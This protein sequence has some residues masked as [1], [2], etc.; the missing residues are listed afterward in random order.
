MSTL[1]VNAIQDT[2][3]GNESTAAEINTGRLKAWGS[4]KGSG[5]VS[6]HASYNFSSIT[7]IST[8]RYRLNFSTNMSD[9]NYSITANTMKGD[10]N[11]DGN[12]KIQC[13]GCDGT[14]AVN[15]G[16][17][18]ARTLASHLDH[19]DPDKFWVMVAR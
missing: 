16:S 12:A 6:I 11:N 17:F 10:S 8:G 9:T 7:D 18:E 3:G 14:P 5:T 13:G 4:F 1:K 19:N 15:V 2:S